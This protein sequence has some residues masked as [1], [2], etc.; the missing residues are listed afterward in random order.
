VLLRSARTPRR[1]GGAHPREALERMAV[2][3][4]FGGCE[5]SEEGIGLEMRLAKPA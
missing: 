2:R 5:I 3:S 4:R 1:A